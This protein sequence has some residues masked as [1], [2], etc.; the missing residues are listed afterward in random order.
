MKI[1]TVLEKLVS[2]SDDPHRILNNVFKGTHNYTR[3]YNTR[4]YQ[5]KISYQQFWV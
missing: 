3:T 5:N 4:N 1:T 2:A